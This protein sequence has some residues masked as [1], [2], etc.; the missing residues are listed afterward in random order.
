LSQ[1]VLATQACFRGLV[2][3]QRSIVT[4][5]G[6]SDHTCCR[7]VTLP[8]QLPKPSMIPIPLCSLRPE[9]GLQ[10]PYVP[11]GPVPEY[12]AADHIQRR[13][14]SAQPFSV[15]K[16]ASFPALATG[17][18]GSLVGKT[19]GGRTLCQKERPSPGLVELTDVTHKT[20]ARIGRRY[21][22]TVVE[23]RTQPYT[24]RS[25]PGWKAQVRADFERLGS[26]APGRIRTCAPASGGRCSIP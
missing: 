23:H 6:L 18:A 24:A 3:Q 12:T 19:S 10:T 8:P 2:R 17:S 4:F 15:T 11:G 13:V 14:G 22:P 25:A 20:W 21:P 16:R 5:P 26:G 9:R 1:Q 7:A